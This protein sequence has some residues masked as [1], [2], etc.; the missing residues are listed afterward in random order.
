MSTNK[1][2]H[3]VSAQEEQDIRL[4]VFLSQKHNDLSRQKIQEHIKSGHV[5]INDLITKK[6]RILTKL[7]DAISIQVQSE[8]PLENVAQKMDLAILF[9]DDDIMVINKPSGLVVHPG[10]GQVDNT[11]LNGLL[12]HNQSQANLPRAGIVH[13]LDKDTSGLMVVA[14]SA[15]AYQNL[16]DM[17]KNRHVKRTYHALAFG[18]TQHHWTTDQPIGRHTTQRTLMSIS[19]NGKHAITHFFKIKEIGPFT[20]LKCQ[21]ETGRTHQIRVHLLHEGHPIAG[22][23]TYKRA[24]KLPFKIS[25]DI[26][27]AL[28]FL[29]RQFLHASELSFKHPTQDAHIDLSAPYPD[30]LN[31]IIKLLE[32]TYEP[33]H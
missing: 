11:L 5:C 27:Q 3:I 2:S 30:D 24:V 19:P 25:L 1:I 16:V 20:L 15:L 29:N 7:G 21:L 10:A 23:K 31:Q 6:P 18:H 8:Q 14:K 4:D 22:D 32:S 28:S 33:N 13:R 12:Y 17:I 9:E 26:T